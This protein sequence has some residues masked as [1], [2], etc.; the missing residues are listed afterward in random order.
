[1]MGWDDMF[2]GQIS[3]VGR[4][5]RRRWNYGSGGVGV[6]GNWDVGVVL[7]RCWVAVEW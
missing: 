5:E 6:E 3:E 4:E 7:G 2:I 1:M